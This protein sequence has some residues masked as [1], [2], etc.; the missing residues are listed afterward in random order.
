MQ[1]A[2]DS[3]LCHHGRCRREAQC[4]QSRQREK[5]RDPVD[6]AECSSDGRQE[7][8]AVPVASF[9]YRGRVSPARGIERHGVCGLAVVAITLNQYESG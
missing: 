2:I 9:W 3:D 1:S 5:Q 7:N 6:I 4:S 8:P